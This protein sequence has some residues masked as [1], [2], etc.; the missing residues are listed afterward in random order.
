MRES[1]SNG[2]NAS[3]LANQSGG[4]YFS[5]YNCLDQYVS[6]LYPENL[7]GAGVLFF[8]LRPVIMQ[9]VVK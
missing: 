3:S 6:S 5:E 4:L 1:L 8:I 2:I 7:N 9:L